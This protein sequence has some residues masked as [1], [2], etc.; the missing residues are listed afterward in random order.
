[1]SIY[2]THTAKTYRAKVALSDNTDRVVVYNIWGHHPVGRNPDFDVVEIEGIDRDGNPAT[3]IVPY[4]VL[5]HFLKATGEYMGIAEDLLGHEKAVE[6]MKE[7]I[8]ER[9][10]KV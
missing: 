9:R 10:G 4:W 8:R 5:E 1:M 2:M 3:V 6:A 7:I